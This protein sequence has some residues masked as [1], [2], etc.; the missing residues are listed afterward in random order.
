MKTVLSYVL[1]SLMVFSISSVANA[2]SGNKIFR[3]DRLSVVK[4][5]DATVQNVEL[6]RIQRT[7]RI[8]LKKLEGQPDVEKRKVI[9]RS[10]RIIFSKA[11]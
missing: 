11:I 10:D 2:D 1:S 6:N 8:V 9:R 7:D 5:T 3:T 4:P